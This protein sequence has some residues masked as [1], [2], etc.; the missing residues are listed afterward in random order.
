MITGSGLHDRDETIFAHKPFLVISDHLVRNTKIAILRVDDRGYRSMDEKIKKSIFTTN[1][2]KRDVIAAVNYLS[3]RKDIDQKNIGLIGHSEGA[4]IA[5]MVASSPFYQ[6][7]DPL[8]E[9][10]TINNDNNNKNIIKDENNNLNL[11]LNDI[12]NKEK[13]NSEGEEIKLKNEIKFVV[14]MGGP[15]RKGLDIVASQQ[16]KIMELS[17]M[18][19]KTIEMN[20]KFNSELFEEVCLVNDENERTEKLN[21]LKEKYLNDPNTLK[22]IRE[23]IEKDLFGPV[24]SRWYRYFLKLS[25]ELYLKNIRCPVLSIIGEKD[26]QV[27]PSL[28]VDLMKEYLEKNNNA[29]VEILPNLNH[30]FQECNTGNFDEYATID[31]TFNPDA[32]NRISTWINTLFTSK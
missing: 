1:D 29:T 20:T 3:G 8:I 10:L 14:M 13:D 6:T 5:S 18:D 31:Q 27:I 22:D 19:E 25:P 9:P 16:R 24:S 28:N 11:N 15:A 23:I 21:Q 7:F 26:S 2:F 32:L 17:G 30:L 12:N 4:I